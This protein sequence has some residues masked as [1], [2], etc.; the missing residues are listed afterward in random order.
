MPRKPSRTSAALAAQP[1][2]WGTQEA[3]VDQRTVEPSLAHYGND[4]IRTRIVDTLRRIDWPGRYS[5]RAL[6]N[7]FNDRW[8]GDETGLR[9]KLP[10]QEKLWQ[11][12]VETADTSVVDPFVGEAISPVQ[13]AQG[14]SL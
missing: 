1:G 6:R 14:R 10:A 11:G 13:S 12:A 4:T 9:Q 2:V 7:A 5:G 8:H 3:L